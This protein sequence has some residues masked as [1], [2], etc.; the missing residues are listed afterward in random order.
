MSSQPY[1]ET[2]IKYKNLRSRFVVITAPLRKIC[3]HGYEAQSLGRQFTAFRRIV[4][5]L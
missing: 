2:R 4:V 5:P 1:S 3:L